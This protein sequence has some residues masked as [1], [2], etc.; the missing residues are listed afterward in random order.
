VATGYGLLEP[1]PT[2]AV[3]VDSGVIDTDG[4]RPLAARLQQIYD[5]VD[6]L[7]AAHAP[8][9]VVIED[10]YTEY[11]FPRTALLMAHA[12]GVIC[13][14]AEQHKVPVLA[15]APAEVKRAIA[16]HGTASKAQIQQS[17]QRLLRLPDAPRSSHVADALALAL[18]GLSR[19]GGRLA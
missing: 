2:T 4:A 3:V 5:G 15:L 9:T 12:R 13:L 19:A 10:L 11:S 8:S 1:G 14:A 7:L 6:R 18:T 17:V 16:A